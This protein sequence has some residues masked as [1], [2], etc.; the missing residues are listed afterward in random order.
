MDGE[1]T[2]RA[3]LLG[4]EELKKQFEERIVVLK[5]EHRRMVDGGGTPA[6]TP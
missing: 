2:R 5:A 6:I 4:L 3:T 1:E